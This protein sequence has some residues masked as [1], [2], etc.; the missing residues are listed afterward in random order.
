MIIYNHFDKQRWIMKFSFK[1]LL[2]EVNL[3]I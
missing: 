3:A 2:A 1:K